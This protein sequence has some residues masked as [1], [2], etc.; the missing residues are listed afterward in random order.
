MA[1]RTDRIV[2]TLT[3]AFA[4]LMDADPAAFRAKFRKMAQDPFAFYRGSAC[5][6]YADIAGPYATWTS[7]GCRRR[8]ARIW[9]QGDLHAENFGTYLDAGG[10]LV[11]DVNDF[12]EAYLGHWTWDLRRFV[13]S[14]ALLG[15]QKALPDG[16]STPGGDVRP[17]LRGARVRH[18]VSRGRRHRVGADPGNADGASWTRCTRRS[19][20]PASRCWSRSR[21]SSRFRPPV[22]RPRRGAPARTTSGRRVRA[23]F[24]AYLDTIPDTKRQERGHLR[25]PRHRRQDGLRDR[26]RRAAGVQRA[27]RGLQPGPGQRRGAEPEA[28]QRRRAQPGGATTRRCTTSST[29]TVTGPRCPARAAGPRRPVPGLD[30]LRSGGRG[31]V[32]SE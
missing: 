21:W 9:I 28:G 27:D 30:R 23:A 11:F 2:E 5:L 17:R 22:R 18:Y 6:F 20:A 14:L 31:F 4:D 29:T 13:A 16:A 8:R 24:T 19:C 25:R 12:D 1:E 15:W 3:D 7:A 10:R 32:V 26:Q